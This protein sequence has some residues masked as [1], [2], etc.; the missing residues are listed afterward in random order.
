MSNTTFNGIQYATG[1][2]PAAIHTISQN[3]ATTANA[4]VIGSFADTNTRDAAYSADI[5]AGKVGM[6]CW[7]V[8]RSGHC[9][10]T[11]VTLGWRWEPQRNVLF[12]GTRPS[13]ANTSDPSQMIALIL[14]GAVTL[15]P[16]N[17]WIEVT[18]RSDVMN[19]GQ[20]AVP[21]LYDNNNPARSMYRGFCPAGQQVAIG[22]TFPLIVASGTFDFDLY[23]HDA[24]GVA[25]LSFG[26]SVLQVMDLG[27]TDS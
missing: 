6:K 14:M 20:D 24:K 15:P 9:T 3:L 19:L 27:P 21:R 1:G 26:G 17:R 22:T 2:D 11:G 12:I 23:A 16:G 4:R 18:I 13:A 7:I 25:I 10:Y 8:N 5:A